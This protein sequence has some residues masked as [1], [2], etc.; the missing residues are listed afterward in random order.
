MQGIGT[1][2]AAWQLADAYARE[3]AQ[4]RAP[5]VRDATKQADPIIQHPA[6]ARILD[7]QRAW[8]DAGRVLAYQTAIELDVAEFHPDAARRKQAESWCAIMTPV[9][10]AAWTQQG[11]DG[12]SACLQVFGGHGYIREWGVEQLVRDIRVA[13][14]YEGT[15]EIQANDLLIR[16]VMGDGG[17]AMLGLI[18]RLVSNAQ[19][20]SAE[21]AYSANA[22]A[23]LQKLKSA[24]CERVQSKDVAYAYEVA[25]D[26]LKLAAL[27]F[28]AWAHARLSVPA[29]AAQFASSNRA[30]LKWVGMDIGGLLRALN[31]RDALPVSS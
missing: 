6:V 25:Q 24:T 13:M 5:G 31:Q 22:I 1:L 29:V 9:L 7:T 21:N 14:I 11:F 15:N 2:S 20:C 3:R 4:M 18:E 12:A 27:A 17:E 16:K 8:L 19:T 10:K 23:M 26:Y 30:S 28:S